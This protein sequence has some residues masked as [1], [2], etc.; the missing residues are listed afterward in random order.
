M[1][2]IAYSKWDLRTLPS[3]VTEFVRA[4]CQDPTL[5]RLDA[6]TKVSP[7]LEAA[8]FSVKGDEKLGTLLHILHDVIKIPTGLLEGITESSENPSRKRKRGPDA[9]DG[10]QK[11]SPH[12]T[13][14]FTSTSHH[15]EFLQTMLTAAGFAV[16]YVYGSLDQT[17]RKTQVDNFR[18]G[19]SNILVVT[20]VAARGIDIP[21]LSNAINYSFPATPKLYSKLNQS[22]FAPVQDQTSSKDLV[23]HYYKV[24]GRQYTT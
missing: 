19:R 11:P 21:L 16:S 3:S 7:D 23:L 1:R 17:A 18:R 4:G 13:I 8:V 10:K 15:V 24:L 22:I 20:D 14:V 9:S 12:A 5:V 2:Q 6:D